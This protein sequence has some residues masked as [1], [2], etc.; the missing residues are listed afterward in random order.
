MALLEAQLLP[1]NVLACILRRLAPRSLAASRCVCKSW[2]ALID[3]CHLLRTDLLPLS[4][5]GIFF[6]EWENPSLPKFFA[7]Q[8]IQGKI[9]A[10]LD[11]LDTDCVL[12]HCN[13]LLL[14]WDEVVNPATRQSVT[15]PSPPP[16]CARMEKFFDDRCLVFDPTVSPHYKV[17]HI[18]YVPPMPG[19]TA[20]FAGESEWPPS[21]YP[22]QVFSSRTWRWEERFFVR[23]G[24]ATGTIADMKSDAQQEHRYAV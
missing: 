5:Y 23:K 16:R 15:L 18:P 22:I 9:A 17:L 1:D 4:L 13:G 12:N 11:Y 20:V 21:R 7:S 14:L 8:L 6:M 3:D 19:S 24:K 2:C 10:M